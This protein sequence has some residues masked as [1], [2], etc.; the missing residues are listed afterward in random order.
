MAEPKQM[1]RG[2]NGVHEFWESEDGSLLVL[3][4]HPENVWLPFLHHSV[5][6]AAFATAAE[7]AAHLGGQLHKGRVWVQVH[8]EHPKHN[9]MEL[10]DAKDV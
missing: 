9:R 3:R 5:Q 6:P 8:P 1:Y 4:N 10:R 7:A 2:D